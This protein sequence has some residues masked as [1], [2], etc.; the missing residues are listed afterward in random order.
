MA[1]WEN[2][3]ETVWMYGKPFLLLAQVTVLPLNLVVENFLLYINVGIFL[4]C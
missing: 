1:C 3:Q 2:K 4:E